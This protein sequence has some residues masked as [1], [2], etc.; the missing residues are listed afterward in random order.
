MVL[1]SGS[2]IFVTTVITAASAARETLFE[3]HERQ[4]LHCCACRN[5]S[6]FVE[7]TKKNVREDPWRPVFEERQRLC[8]SFARRRGLTVAPSFFSENRKSRVDPWSLRS[9]DG[10][11]K[12]DENRKSTLDLLSFF[13][14]RKSSPSFCFEKLSCQLLGSFGKK[15]RRMI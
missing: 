13:E 2:P 12:V 3:I 6:N 9:F 14:D 1:L 11:K 4:L 8:C 5:S 10:R 15:N 7:T